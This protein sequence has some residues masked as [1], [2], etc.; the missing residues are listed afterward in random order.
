MFWNY[1][2]TAARTD[3][4]KGRNGAVIGKYRD[5]KNPENT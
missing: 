3:T 2:A 5:P 1:S 4:G